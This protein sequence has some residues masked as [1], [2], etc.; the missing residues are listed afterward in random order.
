MTGI[1]VHFVRR[2]GDFPFHLGCHFWHPAV[3]LPVEIFN[4]FRASLIPPHFGGG[5]LPSVLQHQRIRQIGIWVGLGLVVVDETESAWLDFVSRGRAHTECGDV[6][7]IHHS[8][9]ILDR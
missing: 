5:N 3:D 9:A 2:L 8:L 6:Q 7:K 4:D 1:S